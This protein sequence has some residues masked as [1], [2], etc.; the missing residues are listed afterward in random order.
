MCIFVYMNIETQKG[1]NAYE[2][3]QGEVQKKKQSHKAS[4][5]F[6]NRER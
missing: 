6:S 3:N 4:F 5:F 1:K 2:S